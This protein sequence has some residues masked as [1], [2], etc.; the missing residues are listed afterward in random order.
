M[1]L[2]SSDDFKDSFMSAQ[3][4]YRDYGGQCE[5]NDPTDKIK[6]RSSYGI[7][8][9]YHRL[10][11]VGAIGKLQMFGRLNA[12][13]FNQPHFLMPGVT[14]RVWL[15]RTNLLS[16][17]ANADYVSTIEAATLY[18]KKNCPNHSRDASISHAYLGQYPS[19]LVFGLVDNAAFNG[20]YGTNPFN[21]QSLDLSY[22]ALHLD[23]FKNGFVAREFCSLYQA[24]N[25]DNQDLGIAI[26]YTDYVL[27]GCCLFAFDLTADGSATQ[28]HFN[29]IKQG[30]LRIDLKFREP[31]PSTTSLVVY[32]QF[33]SLVEIDAQKT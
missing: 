31:L 9:R 13:I 29:L 22:V 4:Y 19:L 16:P 6:E 25:R 24:L 30:T 11:G 33:Q 17:E 2:N 18:V 27:G 1:L 7:V 10:F 5:V 20:T 28:S 14:M 32:A 21:F 3:M 15:S 12:D 8:K 26:S 23:D